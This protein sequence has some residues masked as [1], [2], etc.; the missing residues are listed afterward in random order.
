MYS[1]LGEC[2]AGADGAYHRCMPS[3]TLKRD[4]LFH[5]VWSS[6]VSN[7]AKVL[8]ISDVAL[9]K[10]CQKLDVPRP[11]RGYWQQVSSGQKPKRPTLPKARPRTRSEFVIQKHEPRKSNDEVREPREPPPEVR[12]A[13]TLR[14]AHPA[15]LALHAVLDR[16][17]PD[18]EG[19]L[20]LRARS[21]SC[22]RISPAF[23]RRVVFILDALARAFEARGHSVT[24][25]TPPDGK[26]WGAYGVRVDAVDQHVTLQFFEPFHQ[27][28]VPLE[29]QLAEKKKHGHYWGPKFTLTPS[30]R[31]TM[32]ARGHYP[33]R[34]AGDRKDSP[35]EDQLGEFILSVESA[36]GEMRRRDVERAL[37]EKLRQQAQREEELKTAAAHY[38]QALVLDLEAMTEE[39]RRARSIRAF[40]ADIEARVAPG[41]RSPGFQEWLDWARG[42]AENLDPISAPWKL[43]K[44]LRPDFSKLPASHIASWSH[45]DP[46]SGYR[47]PVED[48]PKSSEHGEMDEDYGEGD[49]DQADNWAERVTQPVGPGES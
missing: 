39:W 42:A 4:E 10:I 44:V 24:F 15:A 35:L 33:E 41:A 40:L 36:F 22:V 13:E 43:S 25:E 32:W 20:Y 3:R 21:E 9:A 45:W 37:Q 47:P 27:V 1:P 34:H 12:V 14:G 7:V 38:R 8:G 28:R 18:R 49:G 29:R 26:R 48:L 2:Q 30:G 19:I 5:L 16:L 46:E 17:E 11:P 31:L 6:P 23:R